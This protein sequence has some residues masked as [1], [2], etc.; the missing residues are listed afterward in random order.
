MKDKKDKVKSKRKEEI[1]EIKD[2]KKQS[3]TYI[4]PVRG[5]VT[6]IV[7][8]KVYPKVRTSDTDIAEDLEIFLRQ[9]GIIT[10]DD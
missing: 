5:K 9:E 7:D 2:I 1:S 8:V 6:Q 10:D 4:C 3:I